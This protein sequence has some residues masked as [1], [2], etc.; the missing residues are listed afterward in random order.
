MPISTALPLRPGRGGERRLR[1]HAQ[2][3]G[4]LRLSGGRHP[5]RGC[6]RQACRWGICFRRDTKTN[7][8]RLYLGGDAYSAPAIYVKE[9]TTSGKVYYI[10]RDYLG[11]ITHI[12]NSDGSLK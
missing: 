5:T 10:C 9:G 6:G 8:E 7:T 11:S 1:A 2:Q 4:R 12:A 3:H